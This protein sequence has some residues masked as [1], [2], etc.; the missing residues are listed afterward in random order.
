MIPQLLLQFFVRRRLVD[1]HPGWLTVRIIF[2]IDVIVGQGTLEGGLT[3]L[4]GIF[5]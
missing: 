2:A 5:A 3:T 4:P 1:K